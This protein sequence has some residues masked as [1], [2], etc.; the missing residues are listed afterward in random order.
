MIGHTSRQSALFFIPLAVQLSLIKDDLLDSIDPLL[1]DPQLIDLVRQKLATRRPRSSSCGRNGIAPDRLLRCA[2][3]KHLKGWSFRELERELRASLLYRR[4]ARFDADPTPDFSTFSRTLGLL[5]PDVTQRIHERVVNKADESGVGHG[6]K[7]P[8]RFDGRG[9]QHPPPTDSTLLGDG[10]RVLTRTLKE[11]R[12][13]L[14]GGIGAS[15]R[16]CSCGEE[17]SAGDQPC[18]QGVDGSQPG[19]DEGELCEVL[20]DDERRHQPG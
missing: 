16:P 5:G 18:R 8:R 15:R 11:D 19:P 14:P 7:A 2:V 12:G 6:P 4:F 9:D 20:G 3:L 1:D 10:I 17:A 13:S